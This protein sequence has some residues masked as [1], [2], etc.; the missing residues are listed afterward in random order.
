[1]LTLA[2]RSTARLA[3]ALAVLAFAAGAAAQ[4]AHAAFPGR[5]G[6]LVYSWFSFSESENEPYPSRTES[7]IQAVAP[8]GGR[9]ATLRHCTRETGRPDVGDC[10]IGYASPAVS[11]DG[12]RVAFDAGGS[13]ALMRIDGGGL[14]LLPAHS[15]DDG[16]PAFSPNGKRIAYSSG[17]IAVAHQPAPPRGIW[18]SDLAGAHARRVTTQGTAPSW[19]THDW[20]AFLRADGVYRTRPDGRGLRRLVRMSRCDGVDW[21]PG[22]TRLAFT[23]LTAHSGGRLYVADGDGRHVRRIPVRYLSPEAVAWAPSGRR[24]AV[25][26]FDG[27][28]V[29]VRLDGAQERGGVGG[30]SGATYTFGASSPDWQPLR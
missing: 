21:S 14:R 18:T 29:V 2:P 9:P 6:K 1:M 25:G 8:G 11:P 5:D 19:S 24:L 17:G 10:S 26:S 28:V 13:L 7:A 16:T 15:A 12:R 4:P 22:G 3:A 23:C 27:S 30:G 20:V